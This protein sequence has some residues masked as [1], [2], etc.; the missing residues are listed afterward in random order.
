M[1]ERYDVLISGGSFAGLALC[2]ALSRA[3]RG[4]LRVGLIDADG[5]RQ[6]RSS[7]DN[8]RAFAVAAAS[9]NL[10][11]A[12]GV[13]GSVEDQAQP[14]TRI[15]ITDSEL[16]AGVR[17]TAL[18]YDNLTE[19]GDPASYIVPDPILENALF[20]AATSAPG[21]TWIAEKRITRQT[22]SPGRSFIHITM[23]DGTEVDAALLV[24]AE[25]RSS[26][27]RKRAG[28]PTLERDYR[29]TGICVRVAFE[30]DHDATAVQHFLPGGPFAI[31]PLQGRKA[32]ITW[33]ENRDV[34]DQLMQD[35][36]DGDQ[37]AFE[38]ALIERIGGKYGAITLETAPKTWP[39]KMHLARRFVDT[40]VVII[41]D[42]ARGVHPIA[43]QGMN[44]GL[45][46]VAALSE[47]V[48]DACR[49][50]LDP[51]AAEPLARYE[52]WRRFDSAMSTAAFDRLN[53][54]FS[55]DWALMRSVRE[56]GLSLVDR[57]PFLK[58]AF[59]NEASGLTGDVPKLLR[60]EMV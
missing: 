33:S 22:A 29:Q 5:A 52:R 34:A 58:Q 60:G 6:A 39:L 46:D 53:G 36:R 21:V 57:V 26:P 10:L 12:L 30:K 48:V 44:L 59:V 49:L 14:V 40:R 1:V 43:G 11:D 51:G 8:P 32:C 3:S 31:L 28:I 27:T 42:A 13:W 35:L 16:K 4:D 41:A 20:D 24:G 9:R 50:G 45:R 7:N 19:G 37:Q 25:G 55:N 18:S 15:E 54:L 38:H 2:V 23:D 17:V 56:T 47:V